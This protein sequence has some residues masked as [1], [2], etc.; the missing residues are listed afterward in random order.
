MD[1]LILFVAII[2]VLLIVI[3]L[4][5]SFYIVYHTDCDPTSQLDVPDIE[6]GIK[7]DL[8]EYFSDLVSHSATVYLNNNILKSTISGVVINSDGKQVI[9]VTRQIYEKK[10]DY[11][12][13]QV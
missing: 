10:T 6:D 12:P 13:I 7:I 9:R 11:E 3:K 8:S 5:Y 4:Q 1:N 2:T